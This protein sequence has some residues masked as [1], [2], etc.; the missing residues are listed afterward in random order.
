M[1]YEFRRPVYTGETVEC[2]A[3]FTTIERRGD[4]D[5]EVA[6]DLKYVREDDETV[7]LT[8]AFDGVVRG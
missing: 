1:T 2:A 7:V 5:W 6:A 8:G 4:G 3:T